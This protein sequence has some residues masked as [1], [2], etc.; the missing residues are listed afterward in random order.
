MPGYLKNSV[1]E[2]GAECTTKQININSSPAR[3]AHKTYIRLT[4]SRIFINGKETS[5][6][7]GKIPIFRTFR[8]ETML[9][10]DT[11]FVVLLKVSDARKWVES[12]NEA[13]TW[14]DQL[15]SASTPHN[16]MWRWRTRRCTNGINTVFLY[17]EACVS[18]KCVSGSVFSLKSHLVIEHS[19]LIPETH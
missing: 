12:H 18:N 16:R 19:G 4:Y 7:S 15:R 2:N 1:Y 14:V 6:K 10:S 13:R 11:C 5:I 8:G 3:E 17:V 9:R